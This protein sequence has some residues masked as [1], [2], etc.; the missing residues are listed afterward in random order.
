M[1]T[2]WSDASLNQS[3]SC[4]PFM[5]FSFQARF[6]KLRRVETLQGESHGVSTILVTP[7]RWELPDSVAILGH[8]GIQAPG[9]SFLCICH[10]GNPIKTRFESG[11][12]FLCTSHGPVDCRPIIKCGK[13]GCVGS[14]PL[15]VMGRGFSA[16]TEPAT[17]GK[18]KWIS[19]NVWPREQSALYRD[20]EKEVLL[21]ATS[22][23]WEPREPAGSLLLWLRQS[24]R[25]S[26][27][28]Q[29]SCA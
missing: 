3:S 23:P 13:S 11:F 24:K 4:P 10:P 12:C 5:C 17:C 1:L 28:L 29:F 2:V 16:G 25:T 8:V 9:L 15:S 19:R 14:C 26:C 21:E 18:T 22:C 20:A 6:L 27:D 7:C